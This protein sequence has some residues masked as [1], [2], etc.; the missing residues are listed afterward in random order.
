MQKDFLKKQSGF[1]KRTLNV[2]Q[3]SMWTDIVYW[4]DQQSA[5][6]TMQLAEKSELVTFVGK[7]DLNSVKMNLTKPILI[8]E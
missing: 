2:S 1:K 3:D 4:Q 5:E 6:K 7:I 8:E